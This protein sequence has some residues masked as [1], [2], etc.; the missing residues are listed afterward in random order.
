MADVLLKVLSCWRYAL[1]TYNYFFEL[2][3]PNRFIALH[4]PK[5]ESL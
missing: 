3:L 5:W 4:K 2:H 1:H